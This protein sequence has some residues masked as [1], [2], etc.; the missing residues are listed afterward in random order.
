LNE[1]Q[2]ELQHAKRTSENNQTALESTQR[3]LNATHER[4]V[5]LERV[6]LQMQ[7]QL[8][9]LTQRK[10]E[11]E[12]KLSKVEHATAEVALLR[13]ELDLVNGEKRNREQ[14]LEHYKAELQLM[15]Q[16]ATDDAKDR[17]IAKLKGQLETANKRI[18]DIQREVD[19][20]FNNVEAKA[21][22]AAKE[23]EKSSTK[24]KQIQ[25]MMDKYPGRVPVKCQKADGCKYPDLLKYKFA[26]H[27]EMTMQKFLN[28][29]HGKLDLKDTETVSVQ[30]VTPSGSRVANVPMNTVLG[31]IHQEHQHEDMCLHVQYNY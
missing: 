10:E 13:Q 8:D 28:F 19:G 20:M 25:K 31:D 14:E 21:A 30:V 9:Q 24:D 17:E 15:K 18:L 29:I 26:V 23:P 27:S 1:K 16:Q 3:S 7:S 6:K 12:R 4:T 11:V 22:A 5:Q 2:L